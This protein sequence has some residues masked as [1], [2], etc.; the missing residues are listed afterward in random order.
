MS[1][2]NEPIVQINAS[3]ALAATL[4]G[5]KLGHPVKWFVVICAL[6]DGTFAAGIPETTGEL[7]GLQLIAQAL[8]AISDQAGCPVTVMPLPTTGRS[9][10]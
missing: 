2:E 6:E 8:G 4:T 10:G 5:Q 1:D 9:Q 3:A 7:R